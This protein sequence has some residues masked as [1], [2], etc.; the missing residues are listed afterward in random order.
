M[1]LVERKVPKQALVEL[2]SILKKPYQG[3]CNICKGSGKITDK[4]ECPKCKGSGQRLLD[5]SKK[6][7]RSRFFVTTERALKGSAI[8][9]DGRWAFF[10]PNIPPA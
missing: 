1:T 2:R 5:L 8:S 4:S 3:A 7:R 10:M 6:I 9:K